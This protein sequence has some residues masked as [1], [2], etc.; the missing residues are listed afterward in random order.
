MAIA[1]NILVISNGG[2]HEIV[3]FVA[4]AKTIETTGL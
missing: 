1:V 3:Y 4:P 2:A